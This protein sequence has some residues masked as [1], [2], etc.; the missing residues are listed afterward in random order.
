MMM[1]NKLMCEES[2]AVLSGVMWCG[3]LLLCS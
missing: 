2:V 1:E 3:L